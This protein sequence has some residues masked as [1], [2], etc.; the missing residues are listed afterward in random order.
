MSAFIRTT[1]LSLLPI[2]PLV[3]GPPGSPSSLFAVAQHPPDPTL[4]PCD[5]TCTTSCGIDRCEQGCDA[6][7]DWAWCDAYCLW[8]RRESSS[9]GF[10]GTEHWNDEV[11]APCR[12]SCWCFMRWYCVPDET[13]SATATVSSTSAVPVPTASGIGAG[14]LV[15]INGRLREAIGNRADRA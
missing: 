5:D 10:A 12:D 11:C 6:P 7:V 13:T 3:L 4:P 9:C 8:C 14:S 1:I 2:S 15:G